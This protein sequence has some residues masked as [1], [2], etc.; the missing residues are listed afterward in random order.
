M[1]A[2]QFHLILDTL[3]HFNSNKK[4]L[5]ISANFQGG[6]RELR[7]GEEEG[8]VEMEGGEEEEEKE[9]KEEKEKGYEGFWRKERKRETWME[10]G[11]GE[12][13]DGL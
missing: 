7:R 9:E 6:K 4:T 2:S 5:R 11:E 8:L 12:E 10:R 3:D 1:G 13:S